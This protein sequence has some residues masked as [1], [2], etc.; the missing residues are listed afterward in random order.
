MDMRG[1]NAQQVAGNWIA[2]SRDMRDHPVVGMGQPVPPADPARGSYSRYE[3]WQDL[4]MEAQYRPFEIRNK[5][6]V[7]T[8]QR[9]QLM[10][11]RAWLARRWNWTE[12]TVRGFISRLES[13]IM[14]KSESVQSKGQRTGHYSN[15]LTICNYDIY[16]TALE[17]LRLSE[18]QSKVQSRASEGPESNKETREQDRSPNGD[19]S[20]AVQGD[21]LIL[22]VKPR[23]L[24]AADAAK[25]AIEAWNAMAREHGLPE[26]RK[27]NDDRKKKLILRIKEA[28]GF[29]AWVGVINKI[30]RSRIL[31]ENDKWSPTIDF[32]CQPSSFMKLMEGAY[33][34]KVKMTG[35]HAAGSNYRNG[36][37]AGATI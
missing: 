30:P 33:D 2:V 35:T 5:G 9:G 18:G 3:A 13:E 36:A 34:A 16:Q 24:S 32:V 4:I 14:A 17:L 15:V 7:I 22:P 8:L 28:G 29:S 31:M 23:G 12:K 20:P 37:Y 27:L 1:H 26:A 10:A 25:Q 6:K 19:S 21:L 11:A